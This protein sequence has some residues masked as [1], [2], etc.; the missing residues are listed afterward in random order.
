EVV[1]VMR[2]YLEQLK[3]RGFTG[4]ADC[5]P[6]Y[7]GRDPRIL[8]ILAQETGL[9]VL[10]NTG[11]YGGAGD[12]FVPQHAYNESPEQLAARWVAEWNDGMGDSGVR[13]GFIKTGADEATGSPTLSDIDAKLVRASAI[14]SKSTG[15]AVTCHTGG[16]PAGLAASKLFIADGG[17]PD[18]F[19]VAH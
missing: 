10:T 5:T 19:I 15:L 1:R 3:Q 11:Y 16:G 2:P 7:I 9:H 6:A 12:K 8:K 17:R 13:P 4:F 18:R 14:A